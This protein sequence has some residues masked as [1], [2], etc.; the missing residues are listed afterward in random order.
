MDVVVIGSV[1]KVG[2]PLQISRLFKVISPVKLAPVESV[3]ES[4]P[5]PAVTGE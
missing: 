1:S 4:H 5:C 3:L 2:P